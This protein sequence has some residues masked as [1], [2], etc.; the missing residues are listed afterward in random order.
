MWGRG[1]ERGEVGSDH[2][3]QEACHQQGR[4]D[5][6]TAADP[7]V[8]CSPISLSRRQVVKNIIVC[9]R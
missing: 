6:V 1:E 4:R 3:S 2:E 9:N 8:P 5:T 7:K